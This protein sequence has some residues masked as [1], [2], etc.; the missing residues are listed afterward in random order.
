[1]KRRDRGKQERPT[2]GQAADGTGASTDTG[3]DP[4]GAEQPD[5]DGQEGIVAPDTDPA[6]SA[7]GGAPLPR[8]Q[9]RPP[10]NP[11]RVPTSSP[12]AEQTLHHLLDILKRLP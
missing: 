8:R 3:P 5:V 10:R 12:P 6:P 9:P 4:E 1:M 7:T 11:G 2:G